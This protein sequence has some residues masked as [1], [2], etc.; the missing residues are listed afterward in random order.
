VPLSTIV[1]A[2]TVLVGCGREDPMTAG[3]SH[4]PG[5][6]AQATLYR[7]HGAYGGRARSS[8]ADQVV[9]LADFVDQACLSGCLQNCGLACA[10]T[11]GSGKAICI[12]MCAADNAE[13]RANCTRPGDP[14]GGGGGGGG[15]GGPGGGGGDPCAPGTSCAG[16]CCPAGFPNCAT[17]GMRTVCCPSGFPNPIEVFGQVICLP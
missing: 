13:C 16:G 3:V 2:G 8:G 1:P 5:F 17:V 10:G 9:L 12:Q 7:A 4:I 6:T 14:P 15:G 11:S